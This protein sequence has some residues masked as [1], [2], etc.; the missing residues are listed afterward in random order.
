MDPKMDSGFL[1]AGETLDD[2]YDTMRN[3]SPEEV[4]GIMDSMMCAE[5][6]LSRA[7]KSE[8]R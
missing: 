6:C 1:A 5:V 2:D 3:L 8:L 4:I 7:R